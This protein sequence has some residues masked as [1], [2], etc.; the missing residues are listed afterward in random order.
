MFGSRLRGKSAPTPSTFN[1]SLP[2][3]RAFRQGKNTPGK[4][5]LAFLKGFGQAGRLVGSE[6]IHRLKPGRSWGGQVS[7]MRKGDA[8]PYYQC[9]WDFWKTHHVHLRKSPV[10]ILPRLDVD[11][12][13]SGQVP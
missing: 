13:R 2:A 12:S 1:S 7:A 6:A 5:K 10:R 8:S 9:C 4:R 3:P 11:R